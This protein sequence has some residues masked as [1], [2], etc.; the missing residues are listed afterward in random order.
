MVNQK[1]RI[2]IQKK[3]IEYTKE[4]DGVKAEFEIIDGVVRAV[5]IDSDYKGLSSEGEF[6]EQIASLRNKLAGYE[7]AKE[8][9]MQVLEEAKN[10]K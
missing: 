10:G 8:F 4:D 6:D 5:W 1:L 3:V 7:K 2:M 9:F